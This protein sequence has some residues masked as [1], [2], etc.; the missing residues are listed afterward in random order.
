MTLTEKTFKAGEITLSYDESEDNGSPMV[1]LHGLTG[2]RQ[3]WR[4]TFIK[5][6]GDSWHQYAV[7]LRGHGKSSHASED[8]EYRIID[9]VQDIVAFINSEVEQNPVIIGHSLGAMTAIGVC[10]ELGDKVR[11]VILLDPPLPVRELPTKTF[12]GAYNWFSWVHEIVG[13]QPTF[14]Q[15]LDASAVVAPDASEA[16]LKLMA[17]QIHPLSVGTVQIA[18]EDRIAEDFDFAKAL[19]KITCPVLLMYAQFGE[20]GSMRDVDAEFVAEHTQDLTTVKIPYDDHMFY[21]TH[22]DETKPHLDEFLNKL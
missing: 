15:V 8:E 19:Q 5:H 18:L 17:A 6:Y 7:D 9:Y 10:A 21:E 14:E 22:W 11:G 3:H 12:P 13:R 1:L 2:M 16:E 4:R 20:S